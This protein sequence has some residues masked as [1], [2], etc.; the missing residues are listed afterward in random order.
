MMK[1]KLKLKVP[2]IEGIILIILVALV[3]ANS[4]SNRLINIKENTTMLT[5][6][7]HQYE[8]NK[9]KIIIQME[10]ILRRINR[11]LPDSKI[12]AYANAFWDSGEQYGVESRLLLC[13]VIIESGAKDYVVS[14]AGAIG[15]AQIMPFHIN[16]LISKGI[17]N[18]QRDFYDGVKSIEAGA[19]IFS[20]YLKWANGDVLKALAAY[21]AGPGNWR[22]GLGYA[23]KVLRIQE[24]YW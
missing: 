17:F 8:V 18:N 5:N 21:N 23:G 11:Q 13:V 19:Y 12:T 14:S 20:I 22:A 24:K 2:S 4:W 16:M 1:R 10:N 9:E 15:V 7:Q 3:I 6:Y